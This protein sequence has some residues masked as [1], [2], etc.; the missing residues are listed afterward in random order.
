MSWGGGGGANGQTR[1][2]SETKHIP[3]EFLISPLGFPSPP[4]TPSTLLACEPFYE[5]EIALTL[6]GL[7]APTTTLI[8]Q[9]LI[10]FFF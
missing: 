3:D 2:E 1:R 8:N 6:Q 10:I 7:R 4:S 5:S 9:R